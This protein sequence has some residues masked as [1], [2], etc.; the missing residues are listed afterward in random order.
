M[1]AISWQSLSR[2]I[3]AGLIAAQLAVV[4][5]VAAIAGPLTRP[6]PY[7][8]LGS[9]PAAASA[10]VI[11]MFRPDATERAMRGALNA[12]GA[13]LVGGPTAADAY[14]LQVAPA[15]RESA[16]ARLRAEGDVVMAQPID[17]GQ[18]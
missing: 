13:R 1:A 6:E 12:S 3:V 18:S 14:L 8:A 5:L 9:A 4:V 7:R 2:P 10:N 11:V 15:A 17:S 16:L